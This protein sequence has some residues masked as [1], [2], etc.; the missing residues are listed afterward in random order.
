[1]TTQYYNKIVFNTTS[2]KG[3]LSIGIIFDPP[4]FLLDNT[5]KCAIAIPPLEGSTSVIAILQ[6][7]KK[8]CSAIAILQSQ[9]FQQQQLDWDTFAIF[10]LVYKNIF[11]L[12]CHKY[13]K[14]K[15]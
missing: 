10:K 5:F 14:M 6:Y 2:F 4:K 8:S 3:I 15:N 1:M 7:Y 13:S 12:R 9:I 11:E